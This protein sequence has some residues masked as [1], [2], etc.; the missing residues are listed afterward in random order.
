MSEARGANRFG[1]SEA[2]RPCLSAL[3]ER[4]LLAHTVVSVDYDCR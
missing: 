4:V 1:R 2:N 3:I